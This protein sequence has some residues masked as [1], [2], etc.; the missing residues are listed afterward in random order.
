MAKAKS[1]AKIPEGTDQPSLSICSLP[2]INFQPGP[3]GTV[4]L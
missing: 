2:T 3:P 1:I 4:F